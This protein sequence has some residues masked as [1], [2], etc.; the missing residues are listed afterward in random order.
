MKTTPLNLNRALAEEKGSN[1]SD[2]TFEMASVLGKLQTW[3][4]VLEQRCCI[5]VG[6]ANCGKTTELQLQAQLL[7]AKG[8]HACFVAV[9]DLLRD[10]GLERALRG[11]ELAALRAWKL[12]ST[13]KLY[14][15]VDSIDEAVLQ[16]SRALRDC[17]RKLV[18]GVAE[19]LDVVTWVL[20]TRPAVMNSEVISDV[21]GE[22][23]VR[24]ASVS[25]EEDDLPRLADASAS[26][27]AT[28]EMAESAVAA[29]VFRL[30]PLSSVQA[31]RVLQEAFGVADAPQLEDLA[32]RHGLGHMLQSPGKCRLL[33]KL[34][35]VEAPPSSLD[36]VFRRTVSSLL[37]APTSG[38]RALARTTQ[39]QLETD[40]LRLACASTLCERL[41][42][43][44]PAE[45]D[46]PSPQALS[47]RSIVRSLSDSGLTHLLNSDLFEDSGHLQVKLQP[48]DVR[49]YLAARRLNS[50]IL[51]PDEALKVARVLGWRAPMGE[52]GIFVQFMPLAGWLST[53][54]GNFRAE[55]LDLSPQCVAFFGDLRSMPPAEAL[56][57]FEK[58]IDSI[59]GGQRVGLGAFT[60]TEENY[61][62]AGAPVVLS[63]LPA[64]FHKHSDIEAVRELL[65]DIA[66][67]SRSDGLLA[68]M[69]T[70]FDGA[71]KAVV[72]D[73][74][75]LAYCLAVGSPADRQELCKAALTAVQLSERCLRLLFESCAWK[76]LGTQD[77][78]QLIAAA[79][80]DDAPRYFLR[81]SL[82]HDIATAASLPE[83][84]GLVEGLLGLVLARPPEDPAVS[85]HEGLSATEWMAE[86]LSELFSSLTQSSLG[87]LTVQVAALIVKFKQGVLDRDDSHVVDAK[88]LQQ[89]L[90]VPSEVRAEV[91]RQLLV[92]YEA[93]DEHA[94]WLQILRDRAIIVPSLDEAVLHKAE[95]TAKLLR[96]LEDASNRKE[97]RP[98]KVRAKKGAKVVEE[99]RTNLLKRIAGIRAGTDLAALSWVAQRLSST[100]GPSRYGDVS[101][102]EFASIY[103]ED[104]ASAAAA[105][106]KVLWRAQEPRK[107]EE[108][109]HSIYWV[110][111]AGVQGLHLELADGRALPA[112]TSEQV[113]RAL[114]Y[115]LY[116][117]NGL[118]KWYWKLVASAPN[119]ALEFFQKTIQ[120]ADFGALS[121]E[122]AR[123]V[124]HWLPETPPEVQKALA[125]DAWQFIL[126]KGTN[127]PLL[128][129]TLSLLVDKSFVSVDEFRVAA[130][131]RAFE[132]AEDAAVWAANWLLVDPAGFL[133]E[134]ETEKAR[135][136]E[137]A[138]ALL[139]AVATELADDRGHRLQERTI[140][141]P[142]IASAL[143]RLYKAL[144]Q[145]V[146]A[147]G[148]VPRLP[149][150]VYSVTE[151]DR[152][153]R[154]RDRLPELIA[155]TRSL[156]GYLA[157]KE[158]FEEAEPEPAHVRQYFLGLMRSTAESMSRPSRPMSEEEYLEFERTLQPTPASLEAFA[159]QV[160]YDLLEVKE[161]LEKGD[162]SARRFL[163]TAFQ[164][165]SE[166]YVR[167]I[168]DDF[169][170]FLA[171]QLELVGRKR[172]SVFREPQAADDT[173]RDISIAAPA[174]AWKA[175][176]ELKVSEGGWTLEDYRQSLREQLVGLYMKTRNTTVGFFV[177]LL[178]RRRG[179]DT[180]SGRVQF[181]GLIK[182]LEADALEISAE[183]N[184]RVRV[185]GIDVT[186]PLNPDGSLVRAR[187]APKVE[188]AAK[189]AAKKRRVPRGTPAQE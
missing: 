161:N 162:F 108:T 134:L 54:N 32:H 171:G 67:A 173:R 103:G 157:L 97:A 10:G 137:G 84:L 177:V 150:K 12:A 124:L 96:E 80:A 79:M 184:L 110:T 34:S 16:D 164:E 22:L 48:D 4:E 87:V 109:P 158:L 151:R 71:F 15:F 59:A 166:E 154:T 133:D 111:V 156:T 143:G 182:Q 52:K 17:L 20:S 178:Q 189:A 114:D 186:E 24:I 155:S 3:A 69:L 179:W 174:Q 66:R 118:P 131:S 102:D 2:S 39:E 26:R 49:F 144:C 36:E 93:L 76:E 57:A 130:K 35:L 138:A 1:W 169:Q 99:D 50:L 64:L 14:V 85:A 47:A 106:M 55:C 18:E 75:A 95:L 43:E 98:V 56:R 9:R 62:Q 176:L 148:D 86:T 89:A 29:A 139:T 120:A 115:G 83:M 175:T 82:V 132:A 142:R 165:L 78:V 119:E 116:E 135:D 94:V 46:D 183:K 6:P 146:P 30:A 104:L 77:M 65:L 73:E 136:P 149:G 113:Q 147:S 141:T 163:S 44:M 37:A 160:E 129:G 13:E 74:D 60:L 81:Y 117:I 45:A 145:A 101:L 105:G 181:E 126:T 159:R 41:N 88:S 33:A 11:D 28:S 123:R 70:R 180:P 21:E 128:E 121:V 63:A 19:S 61:W 140:R 100:S 91:V 170:L 122:R 27:I 5:L 7:R 153:Q 40:A 72:M 90:S 25:R 125:S 127:G 167:S 185:I 168:E 107:D 51:G 188:K 31:R 152:A 172:Y 112:L 68:P 187:A 38:R 53:L 23:G 58:A 42:I 8:A 92:A